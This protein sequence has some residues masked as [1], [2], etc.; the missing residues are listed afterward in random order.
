MSSPRQVV[1]DLPIDG[2]VL[3]FTTAV[4]VLTTLMFGIAPAFR[5]AGARPIEA[6]QERG[7]TVTAGRGGL[8]GWLVGVQVAL[9]MVLLV[10]A[11]LFVRSFAALTAR[12]LGI[13][14]DRVLVATINPQRVD[15]EPALRVGL[16]ERVGKRCS[17]PRRRRG[18]YLLQTP[19]GGG[20]FTPRV[21]VETHRDGFATDTNGDVLG[22]RISPG[23]CALRH[24]RSK[25]RDFTTR[26]AKARESRDRQRGVRRRFRPA[27]S[28][29]PRPKGLSTRLARS[30]CGVRRSGDAVY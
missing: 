28:A 5:V 3:A 7:R 29:R 4:A 30:T 27:Q 14:P 22:N 26:F 20:G 11:G 19:L 13:E 6:I 2:R 21:A 18:R 9:S 17:D 24:Y 8:M 12:D 10:G 23:W 1:L 15:I 25:R 16:Y